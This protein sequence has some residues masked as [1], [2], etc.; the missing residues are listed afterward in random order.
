MKSKV[1][2]VDLAP[3]S[4]A[5]GRRDF[6]GLAAMATVAATASS[7]PKVASA[8]S[9]ASNQ[10]DVLEVAIIGAGLAGLTAARD[11]Q[12]AGCESFV[13]LEARDRVGGRTL[14]HDL[15]N[16]YFSEAGGQWIGPGQTAVADLARELGVGT[17]PTYWQGKSTMLAGDA[18]AALDL[19]GVPG[20]DP[21]LQRE[22]EEMARS[23]P[24]GA[25]WASPR[26]A[27]LD[28]L[29][30]GDWL[31][32]KNIAPENQIDWSASLRLT[33][34]TS[35]TKLSLLYYLSMINSADCNYE[36]LEGTSDG[37]QQA[38]LSGGSQILSVR[39]ADA[40]G[41]KVRLSAP[42][43]RIE[44]WQNG[45]VAIHTP[46]G[47]IR[48]RNVIVA[49]SPPLCHQIAFDP[50]LPEKRREM[51]RRWPA[52]APMRKTAHVYKKP[53]WRGKGLSGWIFQV[54]GP[55]LWAYDNSPEDLSFGVI[56]AFVHNGLLPSEP[57]AAEAELT[58]IYAQ[59]LGDE[60]LHP[61]GFHQ[62]DWLKA[63]KWT[64]TCVSPMPPGFLTRY[65]EALHP[66]VGRLIWSGTE[67]ADIWAGYMD[68]A[69]RSGHKAALQ[70]LR[71]AAGRTA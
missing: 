71:A 9:G 11:L 30:V 22:L 6:L 46:N 69:V 20:T 4:T 35:P 13:V 19:G 10:R 5:F 3:G 41:D 23:V 15:G 67:T 49:L 56:N 66:S 1:E 27:E 51:Q 43:L 52:Y 45:P 8:V 33:S 34:G 7:L 65:G 32:K 12:R 28:A 17:F 31:A 37:A 58:R 61:I 68:G 44:N 62:H 54:Q 47:V 26:A 63:D 70:V 39:M 42:V 48:A 64:L 38:R 40:L 29:S 57:K 14:N 24:S 53:F 55:V 50:P 21:K 25:P 36:R 16:G 18:R 2:A 59:A 60:A